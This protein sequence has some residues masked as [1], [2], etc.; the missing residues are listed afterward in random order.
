MD[1]TTAA[2]L[3]GLLDGEGCFHIAHSKARNQLNPQVIVGMCHQPTVEHVAKLMGSP[4]RG[5]KTYRKG[6]RDRWSTTL[7]GARQI[8][9]LLTRILPYLVAK[10]EE[11]EL[12]LEFCRTFPPKFARVSPETLTKRLQLLE[13]LKALR[14]IGWEA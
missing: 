14:E 1:D 4:V 8:E 7:C 12:M 11:A 10:R 6:W 3:A 5:V 2:W 9:S 13:Q